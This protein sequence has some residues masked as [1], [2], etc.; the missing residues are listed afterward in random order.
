MWLYG[1]SI[2]KK[3]KGVAIGMARDTQFTLRERL[4]DPEGRFLFLKGKLY[5]IEC[6]LANICV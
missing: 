4:V 5:N 6:T 1:D 3:A 2:T